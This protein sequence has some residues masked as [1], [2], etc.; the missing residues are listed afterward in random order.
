[1]SDI[2]HIHED[3]VDAYAYL[4]KF[5]I[6]VETM[7]QIRHMLHH[8][9]VNHAR[10]M[11]DCNKGMGCCVGFT[12]LLVDKIVPQFIGGDIGCGILTYPLYRKEQVEL[13]LPPA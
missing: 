6:D 11:P 5:E 2:Y 13:D 7:K 3:G 9:A 8:P 4:P 1:M 12:S 10:I